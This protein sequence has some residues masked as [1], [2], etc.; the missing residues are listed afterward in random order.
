MLSVS[1][2]YPYLIVSPIYFNI[3]LVR[4]DMEVKEHEASYF[5]HRH[6]LKQRNNAFNGDVIHFTVTVGS[7]IMSISCDIP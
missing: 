5:S 6:K 3:Y 2:I 4:T 1:L 7:S